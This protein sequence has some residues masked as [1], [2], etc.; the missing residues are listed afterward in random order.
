MVNANDEIRSDRLS[1]IGQTID[2]ITAARDLQ[3][4]TRGTTRTS[5]NAVI[6]TL[7]CDLEKQVNELNS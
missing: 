4:H 2:I 6:V 1:N 5:I 3:L 7:F